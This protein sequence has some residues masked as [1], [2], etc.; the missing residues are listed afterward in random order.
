ML[1]ST[2]HISTNNQPQPP[3][4]DTHPQNN[5]GRQF[6]YKGVIGPKKTP[7]S[8]LFSQIPNRMLYTSHQ[9]H[10]ED[11]S[12]PTKVSSTRS[13]RPLPAEARQCLRQ[14]SPPDDQTPPAGSWTVFTVRCSLERR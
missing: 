2:I 5:P 3:P 11:L 10:P 6:D 7:H 9:P 13:T 12:T 8:G 1:A 4:A 14:L